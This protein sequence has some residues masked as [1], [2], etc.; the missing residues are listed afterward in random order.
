MPYICLLY[1]FSFLTLCFVSCMLFHISFSFF[2]SVKAP[3]YLGS[4]IDTLYFEKRGAFD[5]FQ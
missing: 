5:S 4:S 1:R 2:F 3:R